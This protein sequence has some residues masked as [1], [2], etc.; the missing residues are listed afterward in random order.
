VRGGE[1]GEGRRRND[2]YADDRVGPQP[3]R[4]A[5]SAFSSFPLQLSRT[6]PLLRDEHKK[7]VTA[8][9]RLRIRSHS[10]PYPLPSVSMSPHR[11]RPRRRAEDHVDET[12]RHH[13]ATKKNNKGQEATRLTFSQKL[14]RRNVRLAPAEPRG[15]VDR[16]FPREAV[17][18]RGAVIADL[19]VEGDVG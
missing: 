2:P 9:I 8:R 1:W 15:H 3:T 6:A 5:V 4:S 19:Q 13:D 11:A 12:K 14:L 17:D 7:Q 18:G 10:S 16:G